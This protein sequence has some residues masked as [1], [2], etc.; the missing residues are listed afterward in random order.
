MNGMVYYIAVLALLLYFTAVLFLRPETRRK[1]IKFSLGAAIF[2][3]VLIVLDVGGAMPSGGVKYMAF[4]SLV[5]GC[6]VCLFSMYEKDNA[7]LKPVYIAAF[8]LAALCFVIETVVF[9]F[10]ST[11][12]FMHEYPKKQ[13]SFADAQCGNFDVPSFSTQGS[14]S[15]YIEYK[16]I[17]MP[18]GTITID[19]KSSKKSRVNISIDVTD[20]TH[21]AHYYTSLAKA[22]IIS[23]N[24]RSKTIICNFFGNTRDLKFNFNAE[25]GE[26]ITIK[27]ISVNK[28]VTLHFSVLRFLMLYLL[29]LSLYLLKN[30]KIIQ[31]PFSAAEST[32]KKTAYVFTAVLLI[33][34]LSLTNAGRYNDTGHSLEKDFHLDGG[35]QM[36]KELVDAFKSGT[37]AIQEE[38]NPQL[39]ELDNPYDWSQRDNIAY[40]WDH[41]YY[42][43]K[44]YSYY[45][46]APVILLFLPY[47]LIT[48]YYFPSSWAT[49]LFGVIGIIYLTKFYLLFIKK[50]F[51][52]IKASLVLTG[53]FILQLTSGIY[54]C[55]N[56]A[57]FY[58][59]A[60]AS[61]FACLPSG[62]Y[63]MLK[64]NVLG[65][66]N[67]KKRYLAISA[68][69]LSLGVLCRPTL[70]V[71][72]IAALFYIYAGFA[73]KLKG[74]KAGKAQLKKT[75]ISYFAAALLPFVCIGLVQM[76]YNYIRF[77]SFFDFGIQYSLTINDFTSTEFHSQLAAIGFYN[78]LFLFPGA[79]DSFPFYS[80]PGVQLFSP[81]GYYF[82][83]TSAT[84]GL[85]WRALPILSYIKAKKAFVV[86]EDKNKGINA[87]LILVSCVI[88]PF[89]IIFSIWESG[90]GARYSVDFAWQMITGALVIAFTLYRRS[91]NELK[92]MLERFM[93]TSTVF[94]L[95]FTVGDMYNWIVN[96]VSAEQQAA[97]YS[98]ARLFEFWK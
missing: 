37:T 93:R 60:Q 59:I 53:L 50:F 48:G 43:G 6:A 20:D 19:A 8:R 7:Q 78:Y 34:A 81:Q 71:Y 77:K 41:L 70:A 76:I 66:G 64:S 30:A 40:P 45:G 17:N 52:D 72:C 16:G 15:G 22:D 38:A 65:E 63:Y 91:G 42:N 86:S 58:E 83:A 75:Y 46:I 92:A 35:N 97:L 12:L 18:V 5:L 47:H 29:L 80:V 90:Y 73:I 69:F 1:I 61:G 36:T 2:S 85:L 89:I 49:W 62:A 10:N 31:K 51:A 3:A 55:F 14:G 32:V 28:P 84:V 24:E 13:L 25:D 27:S 26:V 68:V 56:Y 82:V 4:T 98:F 11:H 74:L 57:N 88:C 39:A 95:V 44:I 33:F 23:G 54:L 21:S 67:I 94:A 87:L 9:N 79:A 96:A